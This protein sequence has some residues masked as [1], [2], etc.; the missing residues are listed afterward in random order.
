MNKILIR[1]LSALPICCLAVRGVQELGG[2]LISQVLIPGLLLAVN[3][4]GQRIA[5]KL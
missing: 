2:G 3:N 5:D 1:Y 4:V